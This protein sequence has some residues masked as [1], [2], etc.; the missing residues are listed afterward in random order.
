VDKYH[1]DQFDGETWSDYGVKMKTDDWI[2]GRKHSQFYKRF[3]QS[4]VE[5]ALILPLF[6]LLIVGV[7]I[8]WKDFFAFITISNVALEG[9]LVATFWLAESRIN[10][11]TTYLACSM[12]KKMVSIPYI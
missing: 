1:S 8:Q 7:F 3:E 2:N 12:H 9:V 11:C 5:I 4:I 6:A 10:D